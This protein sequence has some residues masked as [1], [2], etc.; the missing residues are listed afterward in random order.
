M[1]FGIVMVAED[2][3]VGIRGTGSLGLGGSSESVA[4]L[5]SKMTSL[6]VVLAG[7]VGMEGSRG[8]LVACSSAVVI[9]MGSMVTGMVSAEVLPLRSSE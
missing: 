4:L 5:P 8:V 9:G 7:H 1:C 2:R 6:L 3:W